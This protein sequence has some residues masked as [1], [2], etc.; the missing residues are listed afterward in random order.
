M[1]RAPPPLHAASP[2]YCP[3]VPLVCFLGPWLHLRGRLHRLEEQR[4]LGLLPPA[5]AFSG[6]N[7]NVDADQ[8][9]KGLAAPQEGARRGA[10]GLGWAQQDLEGWGS[11]CAKAVEKDIATQPEAM[12]RDP[13]ESS[14]PGQGGVAGAAGSPSARKDSLQPAALEHGTSAGK[15]ENLDLTLQKPGSTWSQAQASKVHQDLQKNTGKA[16]PEGG[17]SRVIS[18]VPGRTRGHLQMDRALRLPTR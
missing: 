2:G 6:T 7:E 10:S 5:P 16:K 9:D 4:S 1:P 3:G 18:C 13:G 12:R 15:E 8:E 17:A 11:V 14:T